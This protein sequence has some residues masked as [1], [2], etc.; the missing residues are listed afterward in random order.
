MDLL[1]AAAVALAL[2]VALAQAAWNLL[3]RPAVAWTLLALITVSLATVV[4]GRQ[5]RISRRRRADGERMDLLRIALLEFDRVGDK[6][7]EYALRDLL[8][9]DGWV[10]R[11]VGGGGD[12]AADVIGDRVPLGR[13]VLQAKHTRV[14]G[15]VGSSVMYQVKGTAGP[16][17]GAHH[18]V[19]VTNGTFT[20]DAMAWG[21]RHGVFWIDRNRLE[22]WAHEGR[23]LDKLL[24][25]RPASS[26]LPWRRAGIAGPK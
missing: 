5:V 10:A 8:V 13:I 4:T 26:R 1:G 24:K 16:V 23:P 6:E 25:L 21:D 14:G 20:R 22:H 11:R 19:V 15:K 9:R 12:Q 3:A 17:H 2:A 18:A 7:F